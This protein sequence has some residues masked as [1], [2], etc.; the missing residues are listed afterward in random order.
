MA[1]FEILLPVIQ[2]AAPLVMNIMFFA[3]TTLITVITTLIPLCVKKAKDIP[4]HINTIVKILQNPNLDS[5][6]KIILTVA[7][8]ALTGIIPFLAFSFIPFTGVPI[9]G[10]MTFPIA[11][12]LSF[13]ILCVTFEAA[14]IPILKSGI[15]DTGNIAPDIEIF[16]ENYLTI[17]TKIGPAWDKF[18]KKTR[19]LIEEHSEKLKKLEK[20]FE[21]TIE[22]LCDAIEESI[23]PSITEL[24]LFINSDNKLTLSKEEI[25]TIQEKLDSWKKV[26]MSGAVSAG[27]GAGSAVAAKSLLVP[28]TFWNSITHGLG[29][30]SGLMVSGTTYAIASVYAPIALGGMAFFF[31]MK[32]L[33]KI[34][35][36]RLSKF[37]ADVIIASMPMI[38][39][40]GKVDEKE[41]TTV[42][43]LMSNPAIQKKDRE[44]IQ[45]AMAEPLD[46]DNIVSNHL[47]YEKN[48][49]K[50]AV[51][52]RLL[53]SISLHIAKADGKIDDKE[54]EMHNKMSNIFQIEDTYCQEIRKLMAPSIA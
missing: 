9:V 40:D 30:G 26:G 15:I 54:L 49:D 36:N 21:G 3:L 39:A 47:M 10:L 22:K 46:L 18:Y 52:A 48:G 8:I 6:Y 12:M 34:E 5:N 53:L 4:N 27:V 35:K 23:E 1:I 24:T 33:K 41:I 14:I 13:L 45:N 17:K 7:L 16:R 37:L 32:G 19:T 20:D 31:S 28:A 43:S 44:R 51:K 38:Y 2:W 50:S 25:D 29:F 11:C 42:Q